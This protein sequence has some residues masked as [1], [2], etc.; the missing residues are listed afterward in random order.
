M[1]DGGGGAELGSRLEGGSESS[2]MIVLQVILPRM[3]HQT[4]RKRRRAYEGC[5]RWRLI[6]DTADDRT[7][8]V[9]GIGRGQKRG[10]SVVCEYLRASQRAQSLAGQQFFFFF[11]ENP[12]TPGGPT[13]SGL[14]IPQKKN[15]VVF[16]APIHFFSSSP[17]SGSQ[18]WQGARSSNYPVNSPPSPLMSMQRITMNLFQPS[19]SGDAVAWGQ[20][21]SMPL[22]CP[23]FYL[24]RRCVRFLESPKAQGLVNCCFFKKNHQISTD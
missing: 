20:H 13:Y 17:P 2:S 23:I 16:I 9:E 10:W 14:V 7:T 8:P 19:K 18:L 24:G 21:L 11:F 15:R 22:H 12:R 5:G 1:K 6:R 3:E 4:K